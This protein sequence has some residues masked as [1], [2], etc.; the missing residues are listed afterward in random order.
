V[1]ERVACAP[2][3]YCSIS[4]ALPCS[5]VAERKRLAHDPIPT[6]HGGATDLLPA[7]HLPSNA[8]LAGAPGGGVFGENGVAGPRKEWIDAVTPRNPVWINRMDGHMSLANSLALAAAKVN[9][10]THEANG[11]AI[12]RD[13]T[14]APTGILKDNATSLVDRAPGVRQRLV[15][16]F[17][18][19][20]RGHLRRRDAA[21]AGRQASRRL[22]AA[23]EDHGGGSAAGVHVGRGVR[24]VRGAA[25]GTLEARKLAD[26]VLL[27]RDLTRIPAPE[28]RHVRVLATVV[29]G[30]LVFEGGR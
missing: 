3:D 1:A 19:P 6:S 9:Q 8:L 23:T 18:D 12:V 30:K 2:F 21:H 28:I 29:G 22:G 16:G 4:R 27:D 5:S 13:D 14:G 20:A 25:K 26:F 7:C 17:A 24:G 15:R 11:G 10:G